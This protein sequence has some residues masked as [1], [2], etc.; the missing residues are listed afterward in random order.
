MARLIDVARRAGVSISTASYVVTGSRSVGE[1]TRRRVLEAIAETGYTPDAVARALRSSRSETVALVVPDIRNPFFTALI[2][3][4][5]AEAR[6]NSQSLLF[7]NT[8][9]DPAREVATLRDLRAQ[10]VDGFIIGL[11]RQ[12]PPDFVKSLHDSKKPFVFVDR[13]VPAG[14]D[15]VT[16]ANDIAAK[17]MVDHLVGIGH[18]RIGMVAGVRGISTAEDRLAGYRAGL[19]AAGIPYDEA[20]VIDGG[21][22]REVARRAVTEALS[23]PD[24]PRALVVSNNDMTLGTL[25][26]IARL[27][28]CIPTDIAVVSLDD[29]PW[30]GVLSSPL[31]A[32]S[33][34]SFTMGREAMRLL[35]RRVR[36]PEA[37]PRWVR[38]RPEFVH[39]QSCGCPP[40]TSGDGHMAGVLKLPG[41]TVRQGDDVEATSHASD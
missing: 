12:T 27:G 13:A 14:V 25:E 37:P 20:L 22:R 23:K 8:G 18:R 16:V 35:L 2:D 17:V 5:E 31:T 26:A 4:V 32:V 3:G 33:Q 40:A 10:R 11:T 24:R 19:E 21:S 28:L 36:S 6:A 9:E 7:V 29:V 30:A 38:L 39:R 41:V 15:Q 1:E 34:P